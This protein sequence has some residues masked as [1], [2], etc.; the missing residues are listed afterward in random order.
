MRRMRAQLTISRPTVHEVRAEK[1]TEKKTPPRDCMQYSAAT[2]AEYERERECVYGRAVLDWASS[3]V[4]DMH[5]RSLAILRRAEELV[6][7]ARQTMEQ[8]EMC[9]DAVKA[10]LDAVDREVENMRDERR[11]SR[12][13]VEEM[14]GLADTVVQREV[15]RS[16]TALVCVLSNTPGVNAG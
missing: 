7:S 3:V 12:W 16:R 1:E 10:R 9:A 5:D 15:E 13:L 8:V 6:D 4:A 11:M 2:H 14:R